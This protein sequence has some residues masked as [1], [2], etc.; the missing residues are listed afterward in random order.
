MT[1][2]F[3]NGGNAEV[4]RIISVRT[5][6]LQSVIAAARSDD[7]IVLIP[8][9]GVR[10]GRSRIEMSNHH[11][12]VLCSNT[13]DRIGFDS[14]GRV[15]V[16]RDGNR[17][18]EH[19]R[20][21]TSSSL[22]NRNSVVVNCNVTVNCDRR[23]SV[24]S[25]SSTRDDLTV[26]IPSI[27]FTTSNTTGNV[28]GQS[29]LSTFAKNI[30][31]GKVSSDRINNRDIVNYDSDSIVSSTDR[32]LI[33]II[34]QEVDNLN[35][36]VSSNFRS[37]CLE[38]VSVTRKNVVEVQLILI[39]LEGK[40]SLIVVIQISS[41]VN[42]TA[43][44]D[45]SL[46]SS[47]INIRNIMDV[48][49]ERLAE[50]STTITIDNFNHVDIRILIR[51][52]QHLIVEVEEGKI[53]VGQHTILVPFVGSI[54]VS[55]TINPSS[56]VNVR[57]VNTLEADVVYTVDDNDRITFN[58]DSIRSNRNSLTTRHTIVDE[59]LIDIMSRILVNNGELFVEVRTIN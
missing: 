52:L 40:F 33:S 26:T 41:Y 17:S 43:L 55:S 8:G 49:F 58:F 29:E 37:E 12:V 6:D 10:S 14:Q 35:D 54:E 46:G 30:T 11:D 7:S 3:I 39:P 31:V 51:R 42:R 21:T 9:V 20:L 27:N 1:T 59:S 28:S 34:V 19:F 50:G 45:F 25:T 24:S 16:D 44:A 18:S 32:I 5:S 22:S 4:V 56:K 36:V 57:S 23:I 38:L 48:N 53:V 13:N 15:R 2:I 47:N